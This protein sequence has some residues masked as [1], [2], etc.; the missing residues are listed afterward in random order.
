ML[1]ASGG[2]MPIPDT[3]SYIKPNQLALKSSQAPM[4]LESLPSSSITPN[5]GPTKA[6]SLSNPDKQSHIEKDFERKDRNLKRRAEMAEKAQQRIDQETI[7][8]LKKR[9]QAVIKH[10]NAHAIAG[11]AL[12]GRPIYEYTQGPDGKRYITGGHVNMRSNSLETDPEKRIQQAQTLYRAALAPADPSPQDR[13]VAVN[14]K[15]LEMEA[16]L[17]AN[18]IEKEAKKLENAE[19]AEQAAGEAEQAAGEAEQAEKAEQ[20]NVQ[21]PSE[22]TTTSKQTTKTAILAYSNANELESDLGVNLRRQA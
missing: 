7:R 16:R 1:M 17:A 9:E 6:A 21:E 14:A 12:A 3:R 5:S 22:E 8:N 13:L 4:Q 19:K 2:V 15:Q 11:G 10:E 20:E 18:E